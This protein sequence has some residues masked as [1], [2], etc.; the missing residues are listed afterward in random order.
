[1]NLRWLLMAKRWVQNPPSMSK[2]MMVGA[3]LAFCLAVYAVETFWGWP[4]WATA[5]RIRRP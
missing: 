5:E 1:M 2:V 3:I 4:D